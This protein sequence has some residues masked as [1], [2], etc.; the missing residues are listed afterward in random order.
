M[1]RPTDFKKAKFVT[2]GLENGDD[3]GTRHSAL[4]PGVRGTF[5][6]KLHF[7]KLVSLGKK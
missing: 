5:W 1:S 7:Q 2:F 6:I 4:K 3:L